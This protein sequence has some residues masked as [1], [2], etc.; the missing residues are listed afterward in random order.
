[1]HAATRSA[2]R[3]EHA[4]LEGHELEPEHARL[5][6]TLWLQERPDGLHALW[7]YRTELFVPAT[8][9]ALHKRFTTLLAEMTE[10]AAKET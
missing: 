3:G 10:P 9:S 5:D 8:I 4:W 7:T 1:V 6:L 2:Y